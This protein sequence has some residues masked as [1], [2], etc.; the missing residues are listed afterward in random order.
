M[1]FGV[2]VV[3]VA[4]QFIRPDFHNPKVDEK[5]ALHA[6][7]QVAVI[8][9]NSCYDC[10]SDETKYPWYSNVAPVSWFM[11]NHIHDG[12]KAIN[13]SNWENIDTDVRIARLKRAKHLVHISL[14]PLSGYEMMH[15]KANLTA[16]QKETLAQFFDE[17]LR[18]L[19]AS[20]GQTRRIAA[21]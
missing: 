1:L 14:M 2:A 5:V 8:L 15:K 18:V 3:A 12:R 20:E 21:L 7:K 4:I 9:K 16:S 13:F 10:H 11:A 17:Q 19:K 6:D